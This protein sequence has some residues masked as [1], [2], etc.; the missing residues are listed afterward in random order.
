MTCTAPDQP[1]TSDIYPGSRGIVVEI[2]PGVDNT[3]QIE[4]A[5]FDEYSGIFFL[6]FVFIS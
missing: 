6:Q 3:D 5:T 1:A 2:Y 4:S